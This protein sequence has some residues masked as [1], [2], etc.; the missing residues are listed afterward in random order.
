MK[1]VLRLLYWA[2]LLK[3]ENQV[4]YIHQ[5][6]IYFGKDKDGKALW[7]SFSPS[8]QPE[9]V[10]YFYFFPTI[11]TNLHLGITFTTEED[12]PIEKKTQEKDI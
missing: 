2:P 10:H 11:V 3:L 8:P 1:P 6:S 5:C 4:T 12:Q 7:S 9:I